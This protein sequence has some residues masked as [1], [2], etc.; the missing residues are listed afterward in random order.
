MTDRVL[1][2][3]GTGFVA[4][5]CLAQLLQQGY[6]ARTTVRSLSR[7]AD[8][9]GMLEQAGAD[10]TALEVVQA[11]L[12]S[13]DGW[14][15]AV[16]GCAYVLHVAS[17]FPAQPP[18]DPDELVRPAR[19]GT[20]R[21]LRAAHAAGVRRVVLTSSYAAIGYGHHDDRLYDENDW[22]DPDGPHV[23]PYELSKTLAERAAWAYAEETGLELTTVNPVVIL[24]PALGPDSSTSLDIVVRLLTG[25][26]P[27]LPRLTFGLVDVRDV[28]DLH[29]RAMT[30]P[31]AA[32][33][34]FL[35]TSA[36][37]TSMVEVAAALRTLGHAARKVPRRT[38]PDIGVKL[39]A[40]FDKQVRLVVPSLGRR[41]RASNRKAV[42]LLGWS[43]RS[44]EESVVDT[45]RSLI[46][47]GIVKV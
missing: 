20:L 4:V 19:E 37:T 15:E 13:D 47:L 1:V 5:H 10:H 23:F 46:D 31:A 18:K 12:L 43:P 22:T 42:E 8:V 17:P 34:R 29:L 30:S 41:N 38:V 11:D 40:V 44:A 25:K 21:V 36:E 6:T 3:G 24:G 45:A 27:G 9:R 14:A 39:A 7:E 35:A 32:G 26:V 33:E 28:A 16:A 2:T